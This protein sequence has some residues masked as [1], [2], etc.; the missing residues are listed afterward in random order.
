MEVEK[1]DAILRVV[2]KILHG[3]GH[4]HSIEEEEGEERDPQVVVIKEK[5]LIA[6]LYICIVFLLK[7]FRYFHLLNFY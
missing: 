3:M 4:F 6:K 2:K 5:N 7:Y 1:Q